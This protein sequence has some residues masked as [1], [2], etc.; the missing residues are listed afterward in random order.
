MVKLF[1]PGVFE[2][3]KID[4][5]RSIT[6]FQMLTNG[7]EMFRSPSRM[8]QLDTVQTWGYPKLAGSMAKTMRNDD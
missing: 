4:Q 2:P 8:G 1:N 5:N 7:F 6:W 3:N